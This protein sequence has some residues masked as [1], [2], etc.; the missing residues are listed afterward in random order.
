MNWDPHW[1]KHYDDDDD[2]W[3]EDESEDEGEDEDVDKDDD[4]DTWD[5]DDDDAW[6]DDDEDENDGGDKHDDQEEVD[7]GDGSSDTDSLI[8]S[9]PEEDLRALVKDLAAKH[10]DIRSLIAIRYKGSMNSFDLSMMEKEFD[11]INPSYEGYYPN[12]SYDY[13]DQVCDFLGKYIDEMIAAEKYEEASDLLVYIVESVGNYV[14]DD[15]D[16]V[17]SIIYEACGR[18]WTKIVQVCPVKTKISI[19]SQ[20][21][22][23]AYE[24]SDY[25]NY[26]YFNDLIEKEFTDR[27]SLLRRLEWADENIAAYENV[28][29]IYFN[30]NPLGLAVND[31]IG[32]MSALGCSQEDID[33]VMKKYWQ[34]SNVRSTYTDKLVAEGKLEEAVQ[35]LLESREL[36]KEDSRIVSEETV[37]L[38]ELYSQLGK[39][40]ECKAELLGCLFG[41]PDRVRAG[42]LFDY[43][44]KLK[45]VCD[46][47]EWNG[48]REKIL[49]DGRFATLHYQLMD[50]EGLYERL[51]DCIMKDGGNLDDINKYESSLKPYFPDRLR[52]YYVS[53]VMNQAKIVYARNGYAELVGYL[54]KIASYPGGSRIASDIA[55]KWKIDYRRRPAFMDELRKAGF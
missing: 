46:A 48:Y 4:D 20:I 50:E 1:E 2:F 29:E 54:L 19:L 40:E 52:D 36:D 44:M 31:K 12:L 25:D 21:H 23:L 13:T 42:D 37:R 6:D 32:L 45:E 18:Y 51:L 38:I 35:V 26:M 53:Y 3:D 10:P 27:D 39:T 16:G 17:L 24:S 22:E 11:R 30:S 9:L 43:I 5:N 49:A 15:Y 41:N 34:I 55:V 7:G 8:D 14:E 28:Q 47:G 33:A